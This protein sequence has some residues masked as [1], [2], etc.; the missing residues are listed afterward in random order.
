MAE[1][2]QP[3]SWLIPTRYRTLPRW[4][5]LA[6]LV[7]LVGAITAG[8][9]VKPPA[10]NVEQPSKMH[11]EERGADVRLYKRIVAEMRG[12][13]D[14]YNAAAD[15]LRAGHFPLKPFAAFRLPTLA[16][17]QA[18]TPEFLPR[19]VMILLV[20]ATAFAWYARLKSVFGSFAPAAIGALLGLSGSAIMTEPLMLM[21][22][23][24]WAAILIALSLALRRDGKWAASVVA[25]FAAVMIRETAIAYVLGMAVLA[26][27]GG[28]RREA[29]GW[30]AIVPVFGAYL[31]WHAAHVAAVVMP[32][33]LR[34]P[35]WIGLGGWSFYISATHLTTALTELPKWCAAIL[36]PLAWFGWAGLRADLG[37]RAAAIIGG[38]GL[39]MMIFARPDNFYWGLL[40]AP[41]LLCGFVFVP[42]AFRD[43]FAAL[44]QGHLDSGAPARQ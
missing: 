8:L 11:H 17:F 2:K 22:H 37:L 6:V 1:V 4:A 38:Y 29:L 18:Y 34:S 41:I 36:V 30:T 24:S 28:K 42:A 16:A 15:G 23:E 27:L 31:A 32:T 21:F 33:D 13:A 35:G 19:I 9:W 10:I 14:Y 3:P 20:L 43:I 7:L 25:G 12:G 40:T 5:A 39:V 44:K 26:F